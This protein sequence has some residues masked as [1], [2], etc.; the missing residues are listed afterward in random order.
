MDRWLIAVTALPAN[1][2]ITLAVVGSLLLHGIGIAA[3]VTL[4]AFWPSAPLEARSLQ[5]IRLTIERSDPAEEAPATQSSYV[6]TPDDFKSDRPPERPAFESDKDTLAASERPPA[7]PAAAALPSQEGREVPVFEFDTRPY[8]PGEKAADAATA[9]A[10]PAAT[11]AKAMPTEKSVAKQR[12]KPS[13]KPQDTPAPQEFALLQPAPNPTRQPPEPN[14]GTTEPE[15]AATPRVPRPPPPSPRA[16]PPSVASVGPTVTPGYQ[17]QTERVKIAGGIDNRGRSSVAALGTP[18]GR[19][20]KAM[21]DAVGMRWYYGVRQRIDL[22]NR[23]VVTIRFFIT[24][25]GRV[26]NP[27]ILSGNNTG[28]LADVSLQAVLEAHLPPMPPDVANSLPGGRLE[29]TYR[30]E[31]Y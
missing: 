23:G 10:A 15:P 6:R 30:F 8:R 22:I 18:L 14:P 26:Q 1:R 4:N 27:Q 20:Q 17:Q 24:P 12:S 2:K 3:V 31:E 9:A 25:Q 7:D 5:P 13:S 11:P 29:V 21:Q 28:V 16:A 19:Y